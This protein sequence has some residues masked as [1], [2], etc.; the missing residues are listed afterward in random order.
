MPARRPRLM[1]WPVNAWFSTAGSVPAMRL[2]TVLAAWAPS[3]MGG[4]AAHPQRLAR[5]CGRVA[6]GHDAGVVDAG[7][8]LV[9]EQ[10]AERVGAQPAAGGQVRHAEP[11][12]PDRHRAGQLATVGEHYRVRAHLGHHRGR[13]A[14]R[15]RASP[16]AWRPSAR[17]GSL[18]Y[19]PSRPPHTS[20]TT[21]PCSAS[22]AAVSM[23]VGPAPTTVTGA[24][25]MQSSMRSAQPL[26]VL[27]FRD[28]IGEFGRAGHG[29]R[30]RPVLPTA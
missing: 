15:R 19:G 10:P 13:R 7:Q 28:G 30:R 12:R 27:E 14:R 23:P 22:S 5:R 21:R 20:V 9:G 11:G 17:P 24:S 1:H 26:R 8:R 25:G 29:R 2:S 18:R 4:L 16:A 3:G 6:G